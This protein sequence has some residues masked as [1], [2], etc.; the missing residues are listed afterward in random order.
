LDEYKIYK[1][2]STA[3]WAFHTTTT[4]TFYVDTGVSGAT[5]N[6]QVNNKEI[7]YRIRAVDVNANESSDSGIMLFN[8]SG[9]PQTKMNDSNNNIVPEKFSLDQNYP[10]PFN[11][12]TK[13]SFF[14]D[15]A[16]QIEL[17][18]YSISGQKIR[19]LVNSSLPE[20]RHWYIW[21][22]MNSNGEEVGSGI[23]LYELRGIDRQRVR[24]MF[25]T[26]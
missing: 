14:I 21:D 12:E 15:I 25:L 19:T 16:Q 8:R 26:K 3:A 1:K 20:G 4:D 18:I 17:N 23:Y 2:D 22:G 24:K 13:I 11:P 6:P 7:R 9:N 5:L 10:N